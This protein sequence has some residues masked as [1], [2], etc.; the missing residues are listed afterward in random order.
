MAIPSSPDFDAMRRPAKDKLHQAQQT[1]MSSKPIAITLSTARQQ[2]ERCTQHE[3]EAK[4]LADQGIV[5]R[6]EAETELY[7]VRKS[8]A[9]LEAEL[10]SS[11]DQPNIPEA[12]FQ[13]L[14]AAAPAMME[15]LSAQQGAHPIHQHHAQARPG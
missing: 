4:V 13:S 3:A 10:R 5:V 2:V 14:A 15:M 12:A 9:L 11:P 1:L 6:E 7:Q 8:C